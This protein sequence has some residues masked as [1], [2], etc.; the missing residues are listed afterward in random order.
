MKLKF[1]F[2]ILLPI[3][4]VGCGGGNSSNDNPP[5]PH[6]WP[7]DTG[8]V[9]VI[10]KAVPTCPS[11]VDVVIPFRFIEEDGTQSIESIE[12]HPIND[13]NLDSSLSFSLPKNENIT[14]IVDPYDFQCGGVWYTYRTPTSN[15]FTPTDEK[16][17]IYVTAQEVTRGQKSF[18][19]AMPQEN[20][21][22]SKWNYGNL[23]N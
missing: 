19:F 17:T 14:L 21:A 18:H 11:S 22:S 15:V 3:F 9:Y 5:K 2:I 13:S 12:F 8:I 6:P 23:T 20:T 1:F 4:L 10:F 16:V 7:K